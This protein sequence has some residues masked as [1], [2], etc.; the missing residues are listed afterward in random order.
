ME[1]NQIKFFAAPSRNSSQGFTL[2]E[3]MMVALIIALVALPGG[4]LML[5][6]VKNSIF[7]PSKLNM[8]MIAS[9]AL[10]IMIEGDAQA[11]GLRF[12]RVITN[13]QDYEVTFVNQNNQTVRYRLNTTVNPNLLYRSITGGAETLIPYYVP[14]AGV[15]LAG[16]NNK[17]FTYYDVNEAV[18]TN[19]ASVRWIAMNL[20]A[21][22]GSGS[23]A[24]WE[25]Q[26]EQAS[27]VAV[28]K[29]Q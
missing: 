6:M 11:R 4:Y 25:G 14:S 24:N 8:D 27:S 7:I 21:Q 19:P 3:L 18:T 9:D 12:G 23:Y 17:V 5:H 10:D 13:I 15:S 16:K 1:Y 2:I 29:Y 26:S 20:I 22:T 28:N